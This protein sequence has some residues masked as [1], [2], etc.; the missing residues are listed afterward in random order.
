MYRNT[1]L[2]RVQPAN[3]LNYCNS[4]FAFCSLKRCTLLSGVTEISLAAAEAQAE[5]AESGFLPLGG[6][7]PALEEAGSH[8][9]SGSSPS[10]QQHLQRVSVTGW[11]QTGDS[12]W[13]ALYTQFS[14]SQ[15]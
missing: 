6:C 2:S 3:S 10:G 13:T 4:S 15:W 8:W 1:D 14:C 5:A 7:P 12:F 11:S 9:E